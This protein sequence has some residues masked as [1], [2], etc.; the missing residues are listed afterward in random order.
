MPIAHNG[1]VALYYEVEGEG[2]AVLLHTGSGGDLRIWREAG[3][4]SGLAGFKVVLM[5]QR[6]R[7]RSGRPDELA[8]HRMETCAEDVATV[9]DAAGV[10]SAA[11]WG[12]S[13]GIL[14]GVAF[15]AA[16]R[17]RLK[18]LVG[19]G[20]LRA[21]N[22]DEMPFPADREAEVARITRL[23][24]VVPDMEEFMRLEN[25]RFPPAIEQ[26]V[27]EGDPRMLARTLVAWRSWHGP[28][29]AFASFPA[30]ALMITGEKED[31]DHVTEQSV[32][33]FPDGRIARLSGVGHLGAFYRSELALPTALPFLQRALGGS[34]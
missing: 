34:T 5:D 18:A 6:G 10:E 23:G 22:R 20:S 15:G 11:F 3:Y 7:G 9:L 2:P 29:A 25:D 13:S 4:P 33:E 17:G 31:P 1:T 26:N 21:V 28:R 27:R 14:V 16:Y 32:T 19:T 12:Y 30:P 8:A 24:G